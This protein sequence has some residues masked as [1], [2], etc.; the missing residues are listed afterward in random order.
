MTKKFKTKT[1]YTVL[2]IIAFGLGILLFGFVGYEFFK[3]PS[4]PD[5]VY[6]EPD[7]K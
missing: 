5:R 4:V 3:S 2:A 7:T 1:D 6:Y